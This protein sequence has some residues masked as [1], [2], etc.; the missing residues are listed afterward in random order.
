[1]VNLLQKLVISYG[2]GTILF[3]THKHFYLHSRRDHCILLSVA[4]DAVDIRIALVY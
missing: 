2:D 4:G 1:M 3:R